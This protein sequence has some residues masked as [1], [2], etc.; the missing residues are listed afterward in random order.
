L[1]ARTGEQPEPGSSSTNGSD[2]KQGRAS[3]VICDDHPIVREQLTAELVQSGR[4]AAVTAVPDVESLVETV[5]ADP[6]EVVVIDIELP[7]DDGF[8]ATERVGEIDG[9]VTA[10]ILSAHSDPELIA[11]AKRRGAAGFISKADAGS[12]LLETLEAVLEGEESFPSANGGGNR[13]ERLLSLSPRE[14]EILDLIAKGRTADQISD[15]LGIGR[16]T[17]Y[18]HVRNAMMRL[19]VNTR[20]EAIA[21]AVRYSYLKPRD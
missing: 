7:D 21:L 11:E 13:I 15:R 4:F 18:T 9:G 19:A 1:P 2:P 12:A 8:N 3:V 20:G 10:V 5:E 17:V 14:R 6:P 16:A